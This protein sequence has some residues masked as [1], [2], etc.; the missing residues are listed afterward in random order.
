MPFLSGH[1]H[2]IWGNSRATNHTRNWCI[3]SAWGVL[4]TLSFM[5]IAIL[6]V[7]VYNKKNMSEVCVCVCVCVD[8]H[9]WTCKT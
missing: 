4:G 7:W 2:Y 1:G 9:S 3:L 8:V 6:W 5:L